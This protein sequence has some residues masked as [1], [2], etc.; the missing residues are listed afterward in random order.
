MVGVGSAPGMLKARAGG[1]KGRGRL[2][3]GL[4]EL[5]LGALVEPLDDHVLLDEVDVVEHLEQ[6]GRLLE[7]RVAPVGADLRV[8][9][10]RRAVDNLTGL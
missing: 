2:A 4:A 5:L 9:R 7:Q 3:H 1:D 8:A 10:G 6:V